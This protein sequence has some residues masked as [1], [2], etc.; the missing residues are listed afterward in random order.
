LAIRAVYRGE[1]FLSSA[2]SGFILE[3]FLNHQKKEVPLD[4]FDSLSTREVEV[5]QLIAE[6]HT[7]A[8]IAQ[9]LFISTKTVD[10]HRASLLAKLNVRDTAGLVRVAI[11]NKLVSLD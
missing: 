4:A 2:I 5:L 11:K 1:V 3:D 9:M 6:G 7:N 8:S 10:K